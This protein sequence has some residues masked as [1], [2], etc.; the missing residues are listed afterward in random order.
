MTLRAASDKR[1]S[2]APQTTRSSTSVDSSLSFVSKK[3]NVKDYEIQVLVGQG[4]FGSVQR[5][6]HKTSRSHVAIKTYEKQRLSHDDYR[7]SALKQEISILQHINHPNI[8]KLYDS[9]DTGLKVKLIME[10]V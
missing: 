4:A 7:L 10:Y 5:A 1:D 8:I 6:I 2:S 9:L 3:S